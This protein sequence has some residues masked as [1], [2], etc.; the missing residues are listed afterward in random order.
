MDLTPLPTALSR[1]RLFGAL[2]L[3]KNGAHWDRQKKFKI[4]IINKLLKQSGYRA[5][6]VPWGGFQE[7]G[8]E[9]VRG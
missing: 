1:K 9:E 3:K 6:M 2:K 7:T 5:G 4:L 8:V